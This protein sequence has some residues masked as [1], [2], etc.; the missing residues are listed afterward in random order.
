MQLRRHSF[1]EVCLNTASGFIVSY[2][3]TFLAFPAI[4]VHTS[5]GQNLAVTGIFTVISIVR[6]YIWR[7]L[8][9]YLDNRRAAV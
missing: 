9:N 1:L 7:R 5:A 2:A 3:A 4:G 8:F 6:S